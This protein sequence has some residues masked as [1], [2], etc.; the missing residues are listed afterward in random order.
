ML[1]KYSKDDKEDYGTSING[2]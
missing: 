2:K 1:F